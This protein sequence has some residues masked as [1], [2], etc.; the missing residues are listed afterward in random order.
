M[1]WKQK[2]LV[3]WKPGD[4]KE[5][6]ATDKS[7]RYQVLW[8]DA[9]GKKKSKSFTRSKD[10]D[11]FALDVER[12]EQLGGLFTEEPQMFGEFFDLWKERYQ[13]TVR[14]S[15]FKRRKTRSVRW[16]NCALSRS[17]ESPPP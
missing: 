4:I 1:A 5:P 14:P 3:A 10:A 6:G 7:P 2:Y 13:P 9:N 15:S 16:M 12:R 17:T 8:R 11:A